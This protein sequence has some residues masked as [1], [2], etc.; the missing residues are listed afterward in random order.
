MTR[1]E[2]PDVWWR[3]L[4]TG[5]DP[6][7]PL[8]QLR[9]LWGWLPSHPRRKFCNAPYGG[10][11]IHSGLAFVG[12]VGSADGATDITARGDAPNTG[13]RL[14]SSAAAGEVLVSQE[15]VRAAKLDLVSAETRQ[16]E[17]KGK[18]QLITVE[19]LIAAGP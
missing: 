17:L 14:A 4:L 9:R 11:G 19:V 7:L 18:S 16:L 13:A 8:R 10:I 6:A 3:G 2:T 1:H 5:N 15:A 12:S